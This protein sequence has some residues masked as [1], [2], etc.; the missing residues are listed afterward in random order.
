VV[1]MVWV[2]SRFMLKA[3]PRN[4]SSCILPLAHHRDN[5]VAPHGRPS[6]TSRLHFSHNQEGNHESS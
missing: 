6:L 3:P 2:V 4:S 5:V 1:T